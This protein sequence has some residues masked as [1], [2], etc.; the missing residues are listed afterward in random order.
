[1]ANL[2]AGLW[3]RK[4]ASGPS[5]QQTVT[6]TRDAKFPGRRPTVFFIHGGGWMIGSQS[7]FAA[8]ARVWA[9][10]GWVSVN[11]NYRLGVKGTLMHAD[12]KSTIVH[13]RRA[14]YVDNT[15]V[16]IYGS[17]AGGHL[18]TWIGS[19]MGIPAIA[20]IIAWSPVAS[21]YNVYRSGRAAHPSAEDVRLGEKA[22]KFFS[23]DWKAT[24]ALTYA[25]AAKTPPM[26]LAGSASDPVRWG[27][28]GGALCTA[29]GKAKCTSTVVPGS[30]HGSGI[31]VKYPKL[32]Q[33][34]RDWAIARVGR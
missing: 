22:R 14:S 8:E 5:A 6:V 21:P 19:E 2:D 24:S 25:R 26:W 11:L 17:S 16:I 20:G 9:R 18:A 7:A 32:A 10:K 3:V 27:S 31:A 34:A 30:S 12:V 4:W 13:F 28:Q 15:K 1:V 33:A 23:Y 29:L